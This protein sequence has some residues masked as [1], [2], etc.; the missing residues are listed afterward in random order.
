MICGEAW[1]ASLRVMFYLGSE[2]AKLQIIIVHS[3]PFDPFATYLGRL[4]E[5]V[6]EAEKHLS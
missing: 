1:V 3:M 4:V 5:Q 2:N 6:R